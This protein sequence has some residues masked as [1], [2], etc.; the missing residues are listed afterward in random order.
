LNAVATPERAPLSGRIVA[1]LAAQI[2]LLAAA[3][4]LF[5]Q[6]LPEPS[7]LWRHDV[8]AMEREGGWR[9][10][11]LPSWR[12][13]GKGAVTTFRV[14]FV[15][16]G[17]H[18]GEAWSVLLPRFFL[19]AEVAVNGVPI[20]D[21]RRGEGAGRPRANIPLLAAIP[22][23]ILREGANEAIITVTGS[24]AIR[25][26]L[27]SVFVGPD[28][29]LRPSYAWRMALFETLPDILVGCQI[30]LAVIV[31]AIF[32]VRRQEAA[33]GALGV[34]L[35]LSVLNGMLPAFD[36][37][38]AVL[39]TGA[40]GSWA[41]ASFLLFAIV[42]TGQALRRWQIAAALAPGAVMLTVVPVVPPD[43]ARVIYF[44]LG[45]GTVGLF[46][47]L[48]WLVLLGA[49]HRRPRTDVVVLS[50]AVA[51]QL[52]AWVSDMTMLFHLQDDRRY[53]YGWIAV[54]AIPLVAGFILALR[55]VN[56]LERI[57]RSAAETR[58]E[59]DAATRELRRSFDREKARDR[60]EAL[61]VERSRLMHDLHD[62]LSG[63]LVRI[64]ALSERHQVDRH[65]IEVA[66]RKALGDLRLVVEAMDDVGGDL[67]LALGSWRE[68]TAARLASHDMTLAWRY[69][70][71]AFPLL[72]GLG[73]WHVLQIVRLMDEAVTNAI[74]HSHARWVTIV[75]AHEADCECGLPVRILIADDGRGFPAEIADARG[76]ATGIAGMRRRA[77]LCGGDLTVDPGAH[78]TVVELALPL[79]LPA[80]ADP[81]AAVN[82]RPRSG[83]RCIRCRAAARARSGC[84]SPVTIDDRALPRA[85]GATV[86]GA[87]ARAEAAGPAAHAREEAR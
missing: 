79:R 61:A 39:V 47:A 56:A 62:G 74:R 63:H 65:E 75:C 53:F 37:P 38:A 16:P 13:A 45:P 10:E 68:R 59:L 40:T 31:L 4:A 55:L 8:V 58:A 67:T 11:R 21:S 6:P 81:G 50:A 64:V 25:A 9:E 44:V 77:R 26:Y 87:M 57:D 12:D 3:L 52:A 42:F 82:D 43:A 20:A 2:L 49:V 60:A 23:P 51:I 29:A 30:A 54:S 76:K 78:G 85:E 66:A 33:Y 24:P 5:K 83:A 28:S 22:P 70:G 72:D 71:D 80:A 7:A 19:E 69:R 35:A 73:P 48:S 36:T 1:I 17:D 14:S 32:L 84:T 46:I 18:E 86:E 27:E 15:Q 34:M 41:T